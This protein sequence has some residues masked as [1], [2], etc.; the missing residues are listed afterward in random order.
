MENSVI[1]NMVKEEVDSM[2]VKAEKNSPKIEK[3]LEKLRKKLYKDEELTKE[4]I[5]DKLPKFEKRMQLQMVSEILDVPVNELMLYFLNCVKTKNT[6]SL[7]EMHL[8]HVYFYA[9]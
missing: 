3:E 1:M 9:V 4:D 6:R 5:G 7:V 2:F 8:G